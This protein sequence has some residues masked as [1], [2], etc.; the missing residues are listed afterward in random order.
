MRNMHRC[1]EL[2]KQK[3]TLTET[4]K[5]EAAAIFGSFGEYRRQLFGSTS[6]GPGGT[7]L[8]IAWQEL[9]RLAPEP[10]PAESSEG[11][12]VSALYDAVQAVK[13]ENFYVNEFAMNLDEAA[14]MALQT[15]MQN[16]PT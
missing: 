12:M 9:H 14:T 10:F 6:L 4:Q 2:L 15:Y 8:D 11:D 3:M 13:K 5:E 1:R 16:M 7:S